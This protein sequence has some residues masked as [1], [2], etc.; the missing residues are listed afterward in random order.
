[1]PESDEK[2]MLKARDGDM[3]AFEDLVKRYMKKAYFII[4]SFTGD[5]RVS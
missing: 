5:P 2:L 1:M 3:A 4:L